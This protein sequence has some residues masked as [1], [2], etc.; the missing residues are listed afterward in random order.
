[1]DWNRSELIWITVNGD[2]EDGVG[3]V[4]DDKWKSTWDAWEGG[5][6]RFPFLSIRPALLMSCRGY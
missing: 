5:Q 1:M 4:V 6:E 2:E 3:L